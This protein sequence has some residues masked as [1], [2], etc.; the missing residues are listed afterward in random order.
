MAIF[1]TNSCCIDSYIGSKE[2]YIHYIK[3]DWHKQLSC[4]YYELYHRSTNYFNNICNHVQNNVECLFESHI[5]T[6]KVINNNV[7]KNFTVVNVTRKHVHYI[8]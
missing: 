5:S 3:Y 2:N 1:D 4:F 8:C 6:A 7:V